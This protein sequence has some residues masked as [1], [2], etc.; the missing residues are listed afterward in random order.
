MSLPADSHERAAFEKRYGKKQ[1]TRMVAEWEEQEANNGWFERFTRACAGCGTRV[2]KSAGCNH[3]ICS[4]CQAHFCYRC[5]QKVSRGLVSVYAEAD[6][7]VA[8]PRRP[9]SPLSHA[10]VVVFRKAIRRG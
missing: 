8:T 3:M 1:L 9:V 4:K 10:R 5:G 7:V 2:N 6:V